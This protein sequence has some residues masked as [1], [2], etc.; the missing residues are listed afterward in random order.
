MLDDLID[1]LNKIRDHLQEANLP[2]IV[3]LGEQSAGKTSVLEN[4]IGNKLAIGNQASDIPQKIEELA[5][6]YISNP[7]SLIL[8][9]ISAVG[10]IA[11][12]EA[13]KMAKTVDPAFARTIGVLTKID[14]MDEGTNCR[15]ILENKTYPL[16]KGWIGVVNRGQKDIK[17]K[18]DIIS[19]QN[20]E[21]K[22]FLENQNYNIFKNLPALNETLNDLL[23]K[24]EE[25]LQVYIQARGSDS[26]S[27]ESQIAL[28]IIQ[29][30]TRKIEDQLGVSQ[31][32][33][34]FDE[35]SIGAK[36]QILLNQ[37]F[38]YQVAK[39]R[40]K[41][42]NI[43]KMICCAL[44]NADGIMGYIE[45]PDVVIRSVARVLIDII[46][47]I[48][49]NMFGQVKKELYNCIFKSIDQTC[50][51]S[52]L[53]QKIMDMTINFIDAAHKKVSNN[54]ALL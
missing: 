54:I 10:D 26:S 14:L 31:T 30:F 18:K 45:I 53:N 15:D 7:N 51:Y 16:S 28:S 27:D 46:E 52:F 3:V 34:N 41:S 11:N 32:I 17:K 12:S 39:T 42:E 36:I 24:H 21:K 6:N 1:T 20:D 19:A 33:L 2:Q 5:L 25:I 8:V 44:E 37:V 43:R 4:F 29:N 13:L 35:I 38:I 22:Y 47:P 49:L 48:I 40:S 23:I 9:I 50:I